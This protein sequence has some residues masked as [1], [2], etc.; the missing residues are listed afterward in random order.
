VTLRGTLPPDVGVIVA[1]AGRGERAGSGPL[2]QFRPI[3]GVPLLARTLR[4]FEAHPDVAI[5]V[6]ALPVE[7]SA[8]PPDFLAGRLGKRL[9]L[10]AGGATR[11]ES[12]ARAMSA[13]P[14]HLAVVLV[15]DGARPFVARETI[16]RVVSVARVGH[17]AIPAVPVT[18]SLKQWSGSGAPVRSIERSHLWRAQTPQGFPAERFRELCRR[19]LGDAQAPTDDASL[20]ERAGQALVLVPDRTTNFKITTAD[21]FALAEAFAGAAP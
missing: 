11:A 15:H 6:V 10:V 21:D 13:L 1:A 5:I 18:D 2:K 17:G 4:P 14:S 20:W 9:Q 19:V 7:Y 12:V 3:A 16:D 8:T